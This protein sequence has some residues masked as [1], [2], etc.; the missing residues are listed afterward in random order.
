[1]KVTSNSEA[2]TLSRVLVRVRFE[3]VKKAYIKACKEAPELRDNFLDSLDEARALANQTSVEAERKKRKATTRQ[4]EVGM[5]IKRLQ[6]KTR[7]LES[8]VFITRNGV[9]QECTTKEDIENACKEE[10]IRRFTQC[11]DT[12]PM[13][14]SITDWVGF[15]A[16]K[17]AAE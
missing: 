4:K 8:K 15:S 14:T 11:Y 7:P 9:R 3:M 10:N 12:P 5:S 13:D 2:M 1:M 6:Q 17:Q 16:K